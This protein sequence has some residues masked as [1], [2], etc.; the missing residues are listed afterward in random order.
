MKKIFDNMI[1]FSISGVVVISFID[2]ALWAFSI[3]ADFRPIY[4]A[5]GGLIITLLRHRGKK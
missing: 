1:Y 2:V 4:G 5:L 3:H